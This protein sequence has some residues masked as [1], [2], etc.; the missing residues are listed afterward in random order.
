M[1]F[2]AVLSLLCNAK[3]KY[4]PV[5]G[6]LGLPDDGTEVTKRPPGWFAR[7]G[8]VARPF[9]S[10]GPGAEDVEARL[11]AGQDGELD[12]PAVRLLRFRCCW[13]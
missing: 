2:L 5:Q 10:W 7:V 3:V 8:R 6:R 9:L 13:Q 12:H 4:G 11:P 1:H